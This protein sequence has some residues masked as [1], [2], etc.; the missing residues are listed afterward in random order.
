MD[1]TQAYANA[2]CPPPPP[3]GVSHVP[4]I[5]GQLPFTGFEAFAI[6]GFAVA[7]V[8]LGLLMRYSAR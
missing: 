5:G 4:L 6:I 1:C 7:C 2:P 3:N 8:M